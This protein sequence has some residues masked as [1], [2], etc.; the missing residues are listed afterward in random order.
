MFQSRATPFTTTEDSAWLQRCR[1]QGFWSTSYVPSAP[2]M[3][4]ATAGGA[5]LLW[6]A[7][8][9]QNT[10]TWDDECLVRTHGVNISHVDAELLTPHKSRPMN[11]PKRKHLH[12]ESFQHGQV[13]SRRIIV[14]EVCQNTSVYWTHTKSSGS[15]AARRSWGSLIPSPTC[16][17][18]F[19]PLLF[20][21]GVLFLP[22]WE[23]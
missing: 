2:C 1:V 21:S 20:A 3:T 19:Q 15:K 5:T 12:H 4:A 16:I 22:G 18:S 11:S 17:A 13:E 10:P 7:A 8:W 23:L 6:F 14:D 9:T